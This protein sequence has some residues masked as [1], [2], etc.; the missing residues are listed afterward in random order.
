[1]LSSLSETT[2]NQGRCSNM[3]ARRPVTPDPQYCEEA[4]QNR[5]PTYDGME[6]FEQS[7]DSST[8]GHRDIHC[9]EQQLNVNLQ[10]YHIDND[11]LI[12]FPND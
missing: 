2:T 3:K 7:D 10:K 4:D 5:F 8:P 11:R 9:P 1:M 12:R 6:N